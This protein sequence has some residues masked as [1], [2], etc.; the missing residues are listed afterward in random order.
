MTAPSTGISLKLRPASALDK[1]SLGKDEDFREYLKEVTAA[2][3]TLEI[4][5]QSSVPLI[6]AGHSKQG[7]YQ[8]LAR[9]CICI[10]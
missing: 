7:R 4:G 10:Q 2:F 3:F 8:V 6:A 9:R 1:R 5:G